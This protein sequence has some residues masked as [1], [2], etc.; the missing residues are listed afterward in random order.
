MAHHPDD[1]DYD[2]FVANVLNA[3][4]SSAYNDVDEDDIS[5]TLLNNYTDSDDNDDVNV[6]QPQVLGLDLCQQQ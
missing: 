5:D 2:D 3:T 4:F 1:S 6:Q